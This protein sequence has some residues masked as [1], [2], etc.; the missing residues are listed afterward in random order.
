MGRHAKVALDYYPMDVHFLDD[1]KVMTLVDEYD[2][3]GLAVYVAAISEVYANG[4]YLEAPLEKLAL[5][6]NRKI[7]RHRIKNKQQTME[8]IRFCGE[9]DL[10]D[11]ELL[12]QGVFTSKGI[13]T[14]YAEVTVRNK[15]D[16]SKYWLLDSDKSEEKS[17]KL[18]EK[19]S[20]NL[21]VEKSSEMD[22]PETAVSCDSE[23][24]SAAEM[25]QSKVNKSKVNESKVVEKKSPDCSENSFGTHGLVHLT[26]QQHKQLID[27]YGSVVTLDYIN[28]VD[29]YLLKSG[30]RPYSNHF[31]TILS[32]LDKDRI[33]PL[34]QRDSPDEPSFDLDAILEHAKNTPLIAADG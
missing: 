16:K 29:E 21:Q 12:E 22:T 33:P 20:V 2:I 31:S 17:E 27:D 26:Q 25:Q 14:R 23:K 18:E 5:S 30:K 24:I 3:V 10:F 7:S 9:I 8:I 19:S 11:K 34:S 28:K 6:V 32:W 1:Y 4:Y 15:T 13:Q